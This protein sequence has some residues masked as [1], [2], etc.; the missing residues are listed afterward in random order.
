MKSWMSAGE[1]GEQKVNLFHLL[2]SSL[3]TD[4]DKLFSG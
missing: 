1:W 2:R 4:S 3:F